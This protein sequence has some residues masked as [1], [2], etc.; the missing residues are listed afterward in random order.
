MTLLHAIFISLSCWLTSAPADAKCPDIESNVQVTVADKQASVLPRLTG[1]S[2]DVVLTAK[3]ALVWDI[4]SGQVLYERMPNER[5]PIASLSKLLTALVVVSELPAEKVVPITS[6]VIQTQRLGADIQLPIGHMVGVDDLLAAGLIASANDAMV[7][8]A[9]AV[10][11]TEDK[12][13][14]LANKYALNNGLFDTKVANA[15][16][17]SGA[18]QYST[19]RDV[20][21]M[22][23][24]VVNE[25]RLGKYLA[26]SK[27][28]LITKEGAQ[29][30]YVSTNELLKTYVPIIAAKTGY[31]REAGEN[32]VIITRGVNGQYIGAVILESQARFQDMKVLVEWI[33]RNYTW[34]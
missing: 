29:R 9:E 25:P 4:N 26:Q 32:L 7:A 24:L 18:E 3:A 13:V 20:Q 17:L 28:V 5:R 19:A 6:S 30:S 22:M 2:I 23:L 16:G 33:W 34:Q 14:S 1:E 21:K 15:T 10:A 12:F 31:T 27:G 8:L 11:G